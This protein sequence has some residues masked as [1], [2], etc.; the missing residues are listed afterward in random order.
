MYYSILIQGLPSNDTFSWINP[1][2]Y[3]NPNITSMTVLFRPQKN[4]FSNVDLTN[5]ITNSND[6]ELTTPHGYYTFPEFI[7][8]VGS[9]MLTV[10]FLYR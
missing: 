2:K 4:M 9:E 6:E 1:F 5:V 7:K 10:L 3:R 8:A